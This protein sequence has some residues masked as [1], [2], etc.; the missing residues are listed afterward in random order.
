MRTRRARKR[1]RSRE[2]E[3]KDEDYRPKR[4]RRTRRRSRKRKGSRF[5]E[6]E[7]EEWKRRARAHPSSPPPS[8]SA[9]PRTSF[10]PSPGSLTPSSS[11]ATTLFARTLLATS[12]DHTPP[13]HRFLPSSFQFPLFLPRSSPI[14]PRS[15][16]P[17]P[18][19]PPFD[20]DDDDDEGRATTTTPTTDHDDDA[21]DKP[22]RRALATSLEPSPL[23]AVR[24]GAI[25]IGCAGP[26]PGLRHP[27]LSNPDAPTPQS[28]GGGGGQV[29]RGKGEGTG[30]G[31]AIMVHAFLD[32]SSW[33]ILVGIAAR[34][35]LCYGKSL[36]LLVLGE[37]TV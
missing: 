21:D 20:D 17:P 35:K 30:G 19:P 15:P 27:P 3:Q 11:N 22:S 26:K 8:C 12:L 25:A 37:A 5:G 6:D 31:R 7:R 14:L 36:T 24:A 9:F 23:R 2:R 18:P 34:V 13:F 16:L 1:R 29:G 4:R 28:A 33:P 32:C 10:A